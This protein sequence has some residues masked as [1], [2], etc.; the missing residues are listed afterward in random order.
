MGLRFAENG[1]AYIFLA[2]SLVYGKFIVFPDR[3]LSAVMLGMHCRMFAML[4][5]G[6]LSDRY[7]TQAVYMF[8]AFALIAMAFPFFWMLDT[9][10]TPLVYLAFLLGTAVCHGAMIG[11]LP[12]LVGE[13]LSTEV[14]YT[15]SR[16]VT[17]R[18]Q[19]CWRLITSDSD[20]LLRDPR[21]LASFRVFLVLLAS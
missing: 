7:W 11:T 1:G 18:F 3:S 5:W 9:K 20:R 13:L 8:G 17:N 19:C 21:F 6:K 15:E 12:A 4:G 2:F 16:L 10:Q 14:R